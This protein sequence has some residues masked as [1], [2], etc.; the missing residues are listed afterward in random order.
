[1]IIL[2]NIDRSKIKWALFA[3]EQISPQKPL[4]YDIQNYQLSIT[5]LIELWKSK[6]L[7]PSRIM[8][9]GMVGEALNYLSEAIENSYEIEP[10]TLVA[11]KSYKKLKNSYNKAQSL[12]TERWLN[13]IGAYENSACLNPPQDN[14][15]FCVVDCSIAITID[16]VDKSGN[17]LG[18]FIT[19]GIELMEQSLLSQVTSTS[20]QVKEK[21]LINKIKK[22]A[23][24][25]SFLAN[26]T[27]HAIIGGIYYT[28][29][30]YLESIIAD[31]DTIFNSKFKVFIT[32]IHGHKLTAMLHSNCYENLLAIELHEDLIWQGM[33][34]L[35]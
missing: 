20:N 3:K 7:N 1:M 29:I 26:N 22:P 23:D 12:E 18:G 11:S 5:K 10:E 28:V 16:A 14:Y 31:L 9:S 13:L 25:N 27:Q 35:I 15:A 19:P 4:E 21:P 24:L 17:H 2:I 34:S 32:G 30:S 6:N 8:I 33:I